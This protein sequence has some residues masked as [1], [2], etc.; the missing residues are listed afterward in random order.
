MSEN[1]LKPNQQESRVE[2]ILRS[3][4]S[5]EL[6]FTDPPS[7]LWT[8]IEARS[9]VETRADKSLAAVTPIAFKRRLLLAAAAASLLIAGLAVGL[10]N[11]DKPN[12]IEIASA[13][14]SHVNDPEN[15]SIDGFG[16]SASA[17]LLQNGDHEL[18]RIE[19]FNLPQPPSGTDLE[20]W[21]IGSVNDGSPVIQTLGVVGSLDG[22]STYEMPDDFVVENF[23]TVSLDISY[24]LQDGDPSHSGIS[25]IRGTLV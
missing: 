23:D 22:E 4:T 9:K 21:L 5:D 6:E 1:Y 2:A 18:I 20:I 17:T 11:G 15:F 3:M 12:E 8:E 7:S 25:L 19:R 13:V 14:L 16:R 10:N 24:E